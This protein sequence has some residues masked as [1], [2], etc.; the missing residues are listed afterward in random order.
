MTAVALNTNPL[1]LRVAVLDTHEKPFSCA[2]GA[3][4]SR[5]DLL[6]R[7]E[8]I[9]HTPFE[10]ALGPS[11]L[12]DDQGLPLVP[13]DRPVI[14]V[15]QARGEIGAPITPDV[16]AYW[17]READSD[18]TMISLP[19]NIDS[20]IQR[21]E[22]FSRDYSG[23]HDMSSTNQTTLENCTIRDLLPTIF[24]SPFTPL[25]KSHL[26]ECVYGMEFIVLT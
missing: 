8:R 10:D 2:C 3:L 26:C 1:T 12:E 17:P 6:R 16:D 7:H 18:R 13:P 14:E 23:I 4:F 22:Q 21:S 5:K 24:A 9:V 15:Q 11:R 19:R 25:S 20:P